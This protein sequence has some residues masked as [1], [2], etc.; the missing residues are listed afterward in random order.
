[1]RGRSRPTPLTPEER[2]TAGLPANPKDALPKKLA[3][4]PVSLRDVT[5]P[6][7]QA[8]YQK[9]LLRGIARALESASTAKEMT[10]AVKVGTELYEA[11][12]GAGSQGAGGLGS[13]LVPQGNGHGG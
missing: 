1:M 2:A 5:P 3:P 10:D 12:Y 11:L 4:E 13:K 6:A 9:L 8:G 7:D